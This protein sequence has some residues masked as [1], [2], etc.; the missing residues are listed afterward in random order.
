MNK[1]ILQI[2]STDTTPEKRAN[3]FSTLPVLEVVEDFLQYNCALQKGFQVHVKGGQIMICSIPVAGNAQH[4]GFMHGGM[5]AFLGETTG[6][7]AAVLA[8]PVGKIALGADIFVRHHRPAT[9]GRVYCVATQVNQSNSMANYN[10]HFYR[11][12]GKLSASGS[13]NCVFVSA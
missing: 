1:E 4:M 6:S 2:L 12:D 5:N 7:V 9:E 8:A 3:F 10:L 11:H 13:H